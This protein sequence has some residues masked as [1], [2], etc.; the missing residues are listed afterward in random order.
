MARLL[1]LPDEL[2]LEIIDYLQT[3]TKQIKLSF[4]E[5]GDAYRYAIK[6]DPSRRVKYLHSLLF[7]SRRLNSLLTPIF[8][9]DIFVRE[10]GRVGEKIPLEQLKWTLEKNPSLQE[11]IVSV[12]IPCGSPWRGQSIRDII[13][14]FW[15]PN[16][17]TLTIHEFK[18]WE[19]MQFENNSHFG[20]SPVECLRLID[21]GAHEQALANVLSLPAALKVLHYDAEQGEWEGHYG[22]E[23]ATSWTC[24]AFIRA[25]RS[26]RRTLEELTMT[27]PW[28]DHEGLGNGPRIDLS[29]FT[30]LETLRTYH[31]FL[32]GWDNPPRVWKGLPPSLKVL[33]VF[34]DDT[35]LTQFLWESDDEP[36][37]TFL[38]DLIRNKRAHLPHLRTVAIYSFE[39]IYDS[40]REEYL[41]AGPWTLPSSLAREAEAA[42]IKLDV[43]LGYRDA[44]N[45]EEADVF[46]SLKIS[47]NDHSSQSK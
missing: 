23:P 40:E 2:I 16:I 34:Y 38:L 21:C 17:Q 9:R 14:V 7:A 15:L 33:E 1:D 25:L 12:I 26:Q 24:A 42:G 6:H 44:Q 11:H 19:P 20:T 39:N 8:Y 30:A 41:P 36:Y 46:E 35:D 45:F 4:Y 5:L 37:D 3:D 29:D 13:H 22:D 10:Y 27:R 43:W 47:Q 28:L 32:C 31:V 18:D